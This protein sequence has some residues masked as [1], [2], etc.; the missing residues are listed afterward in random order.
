MQQAQN[1]TAPDNRDVPDRAE[2]QHTFSFTYDDTG[3]V[4]TV[5]APNGWRMSRVVEE[6][7][8][9]LGEVAQPDD[10]IEFGGVVLTAEHLAMHVKDFVES[11]YAPDGKFHIVSKPGGAAL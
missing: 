10:R 2:G 8:G 5:V 9:E 4:V 7:Y 1:S 11:G 6:A 3:E